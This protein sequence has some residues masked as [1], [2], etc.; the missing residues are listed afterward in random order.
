MRFCSLRVCFLVV[1]SV[2][3]TQGV[4]ARVEFS[5]DL[6]QT[7]PVSG[8]QSGFIQWYDPELSMNIREE[9]PGGYRRELLDIKVQGQSKDLFAVPAGYIEVVSQPHGKRQAARI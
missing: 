6:K 5:A 7:S 3:F 2:I 1:T 4:Y 9:R 8:T